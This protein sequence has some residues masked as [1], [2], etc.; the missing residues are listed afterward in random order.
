[1]SLKRKELRAAIKAILLNSTSAGTRVSTNRSENV[2][3]EGLPAI[4]IYTR[5]DPA[6]ILNESP[7]IYIRS[8]RIV[9]ELH[10]DTND[11]GIPADDDL[12]EFCSQVEDLITPRLSALQQEY[13]LK[14]PETTYEGVETFA[15]SIEGDLPLAG[16]RLV[17]V[18]AYVQEIEEV[19]PETVSEFLRTHVDHDLARDG[20]APFEATDDIDMRNP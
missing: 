7:P 8:A 3:S 17:Y 14:S 18:L 10:I 5:D 6:L 13:G 1:M 16:A 2:W 20:T 12:D 15:A 4:V 9:I 19:S 11:D